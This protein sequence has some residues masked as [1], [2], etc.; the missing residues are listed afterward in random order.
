MANPTPYSYVLNLIRQGRGQAE[1]WFDV[2][3]KYRG[4]GSRELSLSWAKAWTGRGAAQHMEFN[5]NMT[6]GQLLSMVPQSEVI[7]GRVYTVPELASAFGSLV[8]S[9]YDLNMLIQIIKGPSQFYGQS[10]WQLDV[11]DSYISVTQRVTDML[12]RK[13]VLGS[14][15]RLR[16]AGSYIIGV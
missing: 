13:Y 11:G 12:I 9:P 7:G 15:G 10:R 6:F 4:V 2:S 1:T 14:N 16:F 5:P 3:L 8:Q